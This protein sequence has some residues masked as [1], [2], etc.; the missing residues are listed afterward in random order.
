MSVGPGR[1]QGP[2]PRPPRPRL[3]ALP[4][5]CVSPRAAPGLQERA[6]Q[7]L[8]QDPQVPGQ[9]IPPRAPALP[10]ASLGLGPQAAPWAGYSPAA[11]AALGVRSA[12]PLTT[13]KG[14]A[15]GQVGGA[16]SKAP[17]T[18]SGREG[19]LSRVAEPR[20]RGCSAVPWGLGR[21]SHSDSAQALGVFLMAW[22]SAGAGA[23]GE[24]RAFVQKQ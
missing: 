12:L 10:D 17:A 11:P 13:R 2:R 3:S 20:R 14:R 4:A 6:E 22:G 24:M 21:A 1:S 5:S 8:V 18:P 9:I 23:R 7:G 19:G 15:Q 16:T